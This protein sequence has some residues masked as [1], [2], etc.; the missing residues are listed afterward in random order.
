M[1]KLIVASV[2]LNICLFSATDLICQHQA[3]C[4]VLLIG[5]SDYPAG[6]G[7][8]KLSSV[9]D[10]ELI[11]KTFIHLGVKPSNI[12][13]LKDRQVTKKSILKAIETKLTNEVSPGDFAVFHFSGHGQQIIDDNGDEIDGLDEALVPFDSPKYYDQT[14]NPGNKLLRDD[15]LA[16]EFSLLRQKLGPEGRLL[17]SF[18]ACH[19]GTAIRGVLKARGTDY[20]MA[21]PIQ[22]SQLV[23]DDSKIETDELNYASPRLA[24]QIVF[25][26]SS[27]KQLSYEYSP[28]GTKTYG[29]FTYAYCKALNNLHPDDNYQ[30]IWDRIRVF[31]FAQTNIQNAYAEGKLEESVLKKI[32]L[33]KGN[34]ARVLKKIDPSMYNI[35]LGQIHG[36][37]KGSTIEMYL[38]NKNSEKKVTEGFVDEVRAFDCDII[39]HKKIDPKIDPSNLKVKVKNI[40]MDEFFGTLSIQSEDPHIANLLSSKILEFSMINLQDNH[41][42]LILQVKKN[43]AK[44]F[45]ITLLNK[46]G[47]NLYEKIIRQNEDP[48]TWL[49]ECVQMVIKYFKSKKLID[50]ETKDDFLKARITLEHLDSNDILKPFFKK[51]EP[52]KII[53]QNTG[54]EGFYFSV[55]DIQPDYIIKKI[56]PQPDEK[57]ENEIDYYLEP[58]KFYYST[59]FT[60]GEPF[61]NDVLKLI[62]TKDPITFGLTRGLDKKPKN[63]ITSLID[64]YSDQN[65]G[66]RGPKRSLSSDKG[67]IGS[68]AFKTLE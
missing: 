3:N 1:N 60:I 12:S 28:D 13:M 32:I 44:M 55:Y 43:Q 64:Y 2:L 25:Y 35:A 52:V 18:D 21:N 31:M 23:I 16:N 15:D 63:A 19:S 68:F 7:W 17:I 10:L 34:F 50:L 30:S 6:S 46:T 47:E 65:S 11:S 22:I 49:D 41:S 5:V 20:I 39:I 54:T 51:N 37:T 4:K 29:L 57:G 27:P 9:H 33:H 40:L 62:C 58:G 56:L 8:N 24:P 38:S 42:E 45:Q 14:N 53:I 66:V 61:G 36:I 59:D 67:F 26:S 48:K